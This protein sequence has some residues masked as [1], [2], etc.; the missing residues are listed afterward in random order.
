M[1]FARVNE[2]KPSP[3]RDI[4]LTFCDSC[5]TQ[6]ERL[7]FLEERRSHEMASLIANLPPTPDHPSTAPIPSSSSL[8]PSSAPSPPVP[9][10]PART[11][12]TPSRRTFNRRSSPL[13]GPALVPSSSSST[14]PAGG[15]PLASR[16]FLAGLGKEN[17][18]TPRK[19]AFASSGSRP[20]LLGSSAGPA[21]RSRLSVAAAGSTGGGSPGKQRLSGRASLS[22]RG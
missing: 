7:Q 5:F 11:H 10:S 13:A 17:I 4:V 9:S 19:A 12:L 14:K 15:P 2:V 20:S 16:A 3:L 21:R 8:S 22:V 1:T 18:G 6:A